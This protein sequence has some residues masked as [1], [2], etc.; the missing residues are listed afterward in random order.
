[1]VMSI[2]LVVAYELFLLLHYFRPN[3]N[4]T[5]L[6]IIQVSS[7]FDFF[8]SKYNYQATKGCLV[9]QKSATQLYQ[10]LLL[11]SLLSLPIMTEL[12]IFDL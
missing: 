6:Q 3:F 12:L 8:N 9:I 7:L 10:Q 5:S 1:M 11:Y 4:Y 2:I